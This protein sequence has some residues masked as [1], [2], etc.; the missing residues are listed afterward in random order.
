VSLVREVIQR[1]REAGL[2]DV[3]VVVGGIIPPDDVNILKQCG[4]AAIYTPK[5]FQLN[6]IMTGIVGLVNA[7]V[8]VLAETGVPVPPLRAT[9]KVPL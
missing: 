9:E 1:L 4:A 7:K 6:E 3:P 5:D 2:G 8:E